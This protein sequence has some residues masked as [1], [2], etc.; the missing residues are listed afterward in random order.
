MPLEVSKIALEQAIRQAFTTINNDGAADGSDPN[1]NIQALA[2]A[3]ATAIHEYVKSAN[4][5]ITPVNSTVLPGLSVTTPAGPGSSVAPG[6]IQHV[7]FGRL[8]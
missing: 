7:G 1:A 2:T 4:V 3:L 8:S 6:I 5:D